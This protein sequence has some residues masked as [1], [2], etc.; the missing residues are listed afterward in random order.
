MEPMPQL[1]AWNQQLAD[2]PN[3]EAAD[4]DVAKRLL[5]HGIE[6]LEELKRLRETLQGIADADWR[7]WEELATPEEFV[8]WAKSRAMHALRPNKAIS[9]RGERRMTP[10]ELN[11]F[12]KRNKMA[13]KELAEKLG[14][15]WVTV[16][17][18]RN[19]H[20]REPIPKTVELALKWLEDEERKLILK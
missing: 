18:W 17:R 11:N 9:K 19:G 13:G 6:A 10:Q 1:E 8:R 16:S 15:H 20:E 14:V 3:A 4:V 7:K 12:L 5:K 2:N